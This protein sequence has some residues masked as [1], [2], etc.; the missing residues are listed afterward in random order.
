[1]WICVLPSKGDMYLGEDQRATDGKG[2]T[3]A[4]VGDVPLVLLLVQ[5]GDWM[6]HVNSPCWLQ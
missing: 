5:H 2:H 3:S 6:P 4:T 1:M